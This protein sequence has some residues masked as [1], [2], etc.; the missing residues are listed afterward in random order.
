VAVRAKV[1][2]DHGE[3]FL[4]FRRH[5]STGYSTFH[6]HPLTFSAVQPWRNAEEIAALEAV[7]EAARD[8]EF[9]KRQ[10]EL[11]DDSLDYR[12]YREG[13]DAAELKLERAL[14]RLEE[15]RRNG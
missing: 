9:W 13:K 1:A 11:T 2:D 15:V 10:M 12:D 14:A 4:E 8:I 3:L 7:A 6:R 5:V